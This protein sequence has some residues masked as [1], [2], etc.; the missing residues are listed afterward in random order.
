MH[1]TCR[2]APAHLCPNRVFRVLLQSSR[3]GFC[4]LNPLKVTLVNFAP[5]Q[6]VLVEAP[7]FPQDL[8]R[9]SHK[10]PLTRTIYIDHSDFRLEDS[11]A[12]Y[13]LAPGKEVRCFLRQLVCVLARARV[14]LCKYLRARHP[15]SPQCVCM[16][17][18]W[19]SSMVAL[20][21]VPVL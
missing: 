3:R 1:S 6:V 11:K 13:G 15:L 8:S 16:L 7:N 19:A 2:G 5:D 21:H 9:G 12:Y 10:V 18:R 20:S 17:C 4:V 14:C